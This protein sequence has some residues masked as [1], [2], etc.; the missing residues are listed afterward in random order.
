[1]LVER[2]ESIERSPTQRA[3]ESSSGYIPRSLSGL[4][5][6]GLRPVEQFLR[7][8]T[9]GIPVSDCFIDHHPVQRSFRAALILEMLK[10]TGGSH[11]WLAAEGAG[12]SFSLVYPTSEVH[13]DAVEIFERPIAWIA[14]EMI[15][16]LMIP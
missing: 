10:H 2:W 5:T 3:V 12:L 7:E 14:V 13:L 4:K 1:M 8:C 11:V 6:V 15:A 16:D 9:V